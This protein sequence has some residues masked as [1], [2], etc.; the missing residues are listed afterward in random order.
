MISFSNPWHLNDVESVS[1]Y[2]FFIFIKSPL[3]QFIKK[4]HDTKISMVWDTLV[5]VVVVV[6]SSSSN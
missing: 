6:G 2:T 4:K 1:F 3:T 5:V